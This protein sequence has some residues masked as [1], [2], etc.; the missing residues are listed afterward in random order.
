MNK[1]EEVHSLLLKAKELLSQAI[2][3]SKDEGFDFMFLDWHSSHISAG[4]E[5]GN[6]EIISEFQSSSEEWNYSSCTF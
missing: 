5:F 6:I 1:R 2:A 3:I 4:I